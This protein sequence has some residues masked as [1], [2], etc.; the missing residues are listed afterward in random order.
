V[1]GGKQLQGPFPEFTVTDYTTAARIL[2]HPVARR[3]VKWVVSIGAQMNPPAGFDE[4]SPKR[5]LRLTFDDIDRPTYMG[6]HPPNIR[7]ID[8]IVGFACK[9]QEGN[10]LVHCA[11]GQSR[12]SATALLMI[13]SRMGVGHEQEAVTHLH[14][15]V[16]LASGK[17]LRPPVTPIH[18]NR[19]LVWLGD[20]YLGCEGRLWTALVR[21]MG[22]EYTRGFQ[23]IPG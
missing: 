5:K 4:I 13:L 7:D 14:R 9:A 21:S 17:L 2:K 20:H 15:C 16:G 10:V 8:D 23:M 6:Y 12:S 18:P 1:A 3:E 19:L 11:A 22:P